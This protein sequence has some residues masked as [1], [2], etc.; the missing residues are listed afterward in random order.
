MIQ[1]MAAFDIV[2][3]PNAPDYASLAPGAMQPYIFF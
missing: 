2:V 1:R 3:F